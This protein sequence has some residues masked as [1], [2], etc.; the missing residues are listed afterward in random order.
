MR[1]DNTKMHRKQDRL[2]QE[3]FVPVIELLDLSW[4]MDKCISC[5]CVFIY[6]QPIT[7]LYTFFYLFFIYKFNKVN[8][9]LVILF[10]LSENS[11]LYNVIS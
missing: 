2:F 3:K 1:V 6:I 11:F 9:I 8:K 5:V 10:H 4:Y 7:H